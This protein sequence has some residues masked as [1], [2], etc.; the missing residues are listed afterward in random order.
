M[1]YYVIAGEPSGDL[2][3]SNLL[4]SI[5]QVDANAHFR[6]WGGDLMRAQGGEIVKHYKELAFM[7]FIEVILNLKTI[8]KNIAFCKEDIL[9][10]KP[11]ALILI[12]YPG[13]NLR[14]AKWA[15]QQGIRVFYYIS[16]TIWAWKENRIKTVKD[17]VERMYVILPFEK[18]FYAD[19][20]V[21]VDYFGHPLVDVLKLEEKKIISRE[22]FLKKYNLSEKPIIALLPGS[23]A[24][25]VKHILP[26]MMQVIKHFPDYQFVVSAIPSLP[27]SAYEEPTKGFPVTIITNDTYS[28]MHHAY[29]GLIKSG[30]SSLEAALFKLP[31][32]VCYLGNGASFYIAKKLVGSRLQ[33]VS[34]VNIIPNKEVLKEL[35]QQDFT[36]PKIVEE[37]RMLLTDKKRYEILNDYNLLISM[38]QD[39]NISLKIANSI[40]NRLTTHAPSH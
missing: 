30:T 24:Q 3:G 2:H 26:V 1:N 27:K 37:L 36:V 32:I 35:L 12:D 31:H 38:L 5:K 34:L 15:K 25:E 33:Y 4:K 17:C 6:C 10:H 11:D 16:P 9:A 28:I 13:F 40:Y 7:G 19:R 39:E 21:E 18:K 14:I 20:G 29:V 8:L 22:D 23:R